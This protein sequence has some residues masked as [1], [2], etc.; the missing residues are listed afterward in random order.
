MYVAR[1]RNRG[2]PPRLETTV[3]PAPARDAEGLAG[4]TAPGPP[5]A[6]ARSEA[7]FKADGARSSRPLA[8]P[9][10]GLTMSSVVPRCDSCPAAFHHAWSKEPRAASSSAATCSGLGWP[11]DSQTGA[12]PPRVH[13][14]FVLHLVGCESQ[15]DRR[16]PGPNPQVRSAD[17][18]RRICDLRR[19]SS[20]PRPDQERPLD[21]AQ[22]RAR[23]QTTPPLARLLQNQ[24]SR[25]A[26]G[27]PAREAASLPPLL[28]TNPPAPTRTRLGLFRRLPPPGTRTATG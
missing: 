6:R 21:P 2:V 25:L 27:V 22:G 28:A 16:R 18:R 4:F 12:A 7:R 17:P 3:V 24:L 10:D 23:G 5:K 9:R 14:T 13:V 1:D 26:D 20:R 8:G 19:R 15:F 11:L